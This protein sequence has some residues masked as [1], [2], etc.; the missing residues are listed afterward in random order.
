MP[1]CDSPSVLCLEYC[2][3]T[4]WEVILVK[5]S[6][7]FPGI[8][9]PVIVAL[10]IESRHTLINHGR[11]ALLSCQLDLHALDVLDRSLTEGFAQPV[12]AVFGATE[13]CALPAKLPEYEPGPR[14]LLVVEAAWGA[15]AEL[16][17]R[18]PV[19]FIAWREDAVVV[20]SVFSPRR[21]A[22]DGP[23]RA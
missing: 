5:N 2:G 7:V 19:L 9:P 22:S 16:G 11:P 10:F 14:R 17:W 15:A 12:L 8:L 13:L 20:C 1:S 21:L 3:T 6:Y 23:A 4:S 18:R